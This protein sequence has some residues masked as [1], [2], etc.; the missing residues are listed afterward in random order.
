MISLCM[1]RSLCVKPWSLFQ[2][3]MKA[4]WAQVVSW[5]VY[6]KPKNYVAHDGFIP[7]IFDCWADPVVH[8]LLLKSSM[9][10]L[11]GW[12]CPDSRFPVAAADRP[13]RSRR[14]RMPRDFTYISSWCKYTLFFFN[15]LFWISGGEDQCQDQFQIFQTNFC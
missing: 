3:E 2:K 15:F 8:L 5:C 6:D 11:I 10:K 7:Y 9:V 13:R 4:V 1:P 12:W 14:S